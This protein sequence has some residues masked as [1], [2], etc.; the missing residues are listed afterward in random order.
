MVEGMKA[1]K[2]SLLTQFHKVSQSSTW[3]N[4]FSAIGF[5]ASYKAIFNEP[6]D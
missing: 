4:D 5:C 3:Q 6:D 1:T 2:L